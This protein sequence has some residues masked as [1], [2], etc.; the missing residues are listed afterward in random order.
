M[1][2]FFCF[3]QI[4]H[5]S[6]SYR[7]FHNRNRGRLPLFKKGVMLRVYVLSTK[8]ENRCACVY[9]YARHVHEHVH[10]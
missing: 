5:S 4:V 8:K 2:F 10:A 1:N 9:V 7:F 3:E 6:V